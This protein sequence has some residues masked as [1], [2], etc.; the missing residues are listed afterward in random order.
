MEPEPKRKRGRHRLTD[1][2]RSNAAEKVPEVKEKRKQTPKV[3]KER[4]GSKSSR[5]SKREK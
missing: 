4:F 5:I 1:A 3:R 2:Q